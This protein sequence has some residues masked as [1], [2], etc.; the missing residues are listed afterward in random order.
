MGD[1]LQEWSKSDIR[2]L[3]KAISEVGPDI[4]KNERFKQISARLGGHYS[5]KECYRCY[6]ALK[7]EKKKRTES[8]QQGQRPKSSAAEP[9][10]KV[11]RSSK[12]DSERP[13]V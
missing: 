5:K 6:K 11:E 4:D 3:K 8:Y 10:D 2:S 1:V 7:A 13:T 9:S 12:L